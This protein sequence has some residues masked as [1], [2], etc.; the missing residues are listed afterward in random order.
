MYHSCFRDYPYLACNATPRSQSYCQVEMLLAD[1]EAGVYTVGP[2]GSIVVVFAVIGDSNSNA[3]TQHPSRTK[4]GENE[5][6]FEFL[7]D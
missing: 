5:V 3:G 7:R 2:R 6:C 1:I 4:Y